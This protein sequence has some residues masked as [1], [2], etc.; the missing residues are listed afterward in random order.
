MGT[1][2]WGG[3]GG[4][5]G[6]LAALVGSN[7]DVA[8]GRLLIRLPGLVEALG[9]TL[10]PP[11]ECVVADEE[12]HHEYE[13]YDDY[14]VAHV[15]RDFGVAAVLQLSA[16]RTAVSGGVVA[17]AAQVLVADGLSAEQAAP[18]A[19]APVAVVQSTVLAVRQHQFTQGALGRRQKRRG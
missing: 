10:P 19:L 7:S 9:A 8:V 12:E 15:T 14:D 18:V 1:E 3:G 5:C 4:H 13:E 2:D 6:C 16:L 11:L 17:G